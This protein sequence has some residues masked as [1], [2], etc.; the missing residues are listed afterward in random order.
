MRF[1]YRLALFVAVPIVL[2]ACK[3]DDT[4]MGFSTGTDDAGTE[5]ESDTSEHEGLLIA[6]EVS[7][8]VDHSCA[9]LE[10]GRVACWGIDD[11][12]ELGDGPE[13][14]NQLSPVLVVGLPAPAVAIDAGADHSCAVLDDGSVWC[15]GSNGNLQLGIPDV[16]AEP[17]GPLQVMDLGGAAI[18]VSSGAAHSCALLQGGTVRCWG[19]NAYYRLG[20]GGP[21][22]D[23]A[24]VSVA[25]LEGVSMISAGSVTSCALLDDGQVRCWGTYVPGVD[26]LVAAPTPI[27]VDELPSP[28]IMVSVGVGGF[29]CALIA[30]GNVRCWG[31]NTSGQ[32][33]NGNIDDNGDE[34]A[35]PL[36]N[37]ANLVFPGVRLDLGSATACAVQDNGELR[38]W[39]R[40]ASTQADDSTMALLVEQL[41]G[42]V[43]DVALGDDHFCALLVDGR[44]Q[45]R[46]NDMAGQLGDGEASGNYEWDPVTVLAV[47]E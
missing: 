23:S 35:L 14:V 24:V 8:G 20:H 26:G 33:G 4:G 16:T 10:D 47:Q 46:G 2:S 12:G 17:G 29:A 42:E 13:L 28:A 41:D 37:V 11:H 44:V 3:G 38:C 5:T 40:N 31:P 21:Q 25:E 9:R 30:D 43:Q 7:S 32:V 45:C 15:W 18:D 19:S 6:V 1:S 22:E 34:F 27:A 39:G 36:V